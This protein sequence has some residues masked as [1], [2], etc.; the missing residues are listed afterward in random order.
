MGTVKNLFR[1]AFR[2]VYYG[3]YGKKGKEIVINNENY[4]VSAHVARGIRPYIDD[5]PLQLLSKLCKDADVVC[6]LGA[7]IGIISTVLAKR[8]KPGSNLYSFEPG[9]TA[10]KYLSDNARVQNGNAK[11]N[12]IN[13]AVSNKNEMLQFSISANTTRNHIAKTQE[14]NTVSVK[15]V[16]LDSFC[17]ER[18]I[19]PQLIKIDIEGAE[20]WALEGMK[21][22]LGNNSCVVLVEIHTDYLTANG[23]T[24]KLFEE[25]LSSIGYKVFDAYGKE[26]TGSD[27]LHTACVI[28]AKSR[29]A[30]SVFLSY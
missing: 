20:Y 10:F 11:I 4:I 30:Q 12:P 18:K 8:M 9:A 1:Q 13:C 26:I 16:T 21:D 17:Q 15:A 28:L 14:A 23:V 5:I 29:P 24:G 3:I 27:M 25:Y 7:N 6:D 22:T 2:D 19:T